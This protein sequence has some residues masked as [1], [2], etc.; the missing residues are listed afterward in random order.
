MPRCDHCNKWI[1]GGIREGRLRFC[2]QKCHDEG[3]LCALVDHVDDALLSQIVHRLHQQSCPS[4]AHEGPCDIYTRHT[5]TAAVVILRWKD[6]PRICCKRCGL[7]HIRRGIYW[8]TL[9]GWWH[10][11]FG[12]V[13]ASWQLINSVKQLSRRRDNRT[14]SQELVK[15]VKLDLAKRLSA[16]SHVSFVLRSTYPG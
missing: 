7:S 13:V 6:S 14:P 15:M 10:F 2:K 3:F 16:P 12:I 5:A 9:F 8:T 1:V 11:P 4:C